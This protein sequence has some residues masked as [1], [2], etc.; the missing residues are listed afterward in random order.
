MDTAS[1]IKSEQPSPRTDQKPVDVD[2]D[3]SIRKEEAARRLLAR[4]G[5]QNFVL[6]PPYPPA[7]SPI[8]SFC[9]YLDAGENSICEA[10][11]DGIPHEIWNGSNQH[12]E[13][14]PGD[15]GLRF[16]RNP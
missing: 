10:F 4:R 3:S 12:T 2:S 15:H 6:D 7:Y 14:F 5:E 13:A 1:S 8:C 9:A 11:P 16:V